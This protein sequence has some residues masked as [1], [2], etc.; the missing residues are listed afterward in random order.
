ME[1]KDLAQE[2]KNSGRER[3]RFKAERET[4]I[5]GANSSHSLFVV[6]F[7]AHAS[8]DHFVLTCKT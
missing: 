5:L 8:W 2:A 3:K 1:Q 4:G 6:N 7:Q